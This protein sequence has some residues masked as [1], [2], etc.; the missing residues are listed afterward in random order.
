MLLS[1]HLLELNNRRN[2]TRQ[3]LWLVFVAILSLAPLRVKTALR[4]IGFLHNAGHVLI[5]GLSAAILTMGAVSRASQARR[6]AFT[7]LFCIALEALEARLY[8]NQFEWTDLFLDCFGI[9]IFH[10]MFW[11]RRLVAIS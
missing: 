9:A 5:F 4:T 8:H 1:V 3:I 2:R 11:L 10:V 6:V 7:L